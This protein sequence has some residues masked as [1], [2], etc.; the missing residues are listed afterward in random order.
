MVAGCKPPFPDIC[1]RGLTPLD[2][3]AGGGGVL[4]GGGAVLRVVPRQRALSPDPDMV[5]A[6]F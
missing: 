2:R 5:H 6:R 1:A 4:A 3:G